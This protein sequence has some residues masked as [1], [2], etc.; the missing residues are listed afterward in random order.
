[1]LL[2]TSI[3]FWIIFE[4][5]RFFTAN[6]PVTLADLSSIFVSMLIQRGTPVIISRTMQPRLQMSMIHGFLY[7]S[8]FFS[9]SSSYSSLFWKRM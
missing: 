7:F 9:I 1:M 6:S 3:C 5:T 4:K 8:I 2:T